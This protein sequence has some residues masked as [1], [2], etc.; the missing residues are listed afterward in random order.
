MGNCLLNVSTN[1]NIMS[2]KIEN[3]PSSAENQLLTEL[4][5]TVKNRWDE[6]DGQLPK[7]LKHGDSQYQKI[8]SSYEELSSDLV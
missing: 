1:T 6:F 3:Q 7:L 4:Q 8:K 5:S 2:S